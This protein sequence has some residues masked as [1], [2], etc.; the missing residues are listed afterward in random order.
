MGVPAILAYCLGRSSTLKRRMKN[1]RCRPCSATT[2][3]QRIKLLPSSIMPIYSIVDRGGKEIF[4]V[5]S[6]RVLSKYWASKS[7]PYLPESSNLKGGKCLTSKNTMTD[8]CQRD[9][10]GC[11][12]LCVQSPRPYFSRTNSLIR[13]RGTPPNSLVTPHFSFSRLRTSLLSR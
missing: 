3:L 8:P 11:Q 13:E 5:C 12:N 2:I 10:T 4:L 6:K 9:E 7:L 1:R